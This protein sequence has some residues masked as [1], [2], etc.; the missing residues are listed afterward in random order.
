M[1]EQRVC[2]H[3]GCDRWKAERADKLAARMVS[4]ERERTRL[5]QENGVLRSE[6]HLARELGQEVRNAMQRRIQRQ[7]RVIRRLEQKLLDAGRQP[8]DDATLGD[9]LPVTTIP[10]IGDR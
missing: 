3:C 9:G 5:A 2:P 1:G 8:H 10:E 4:T 7:A 6:A